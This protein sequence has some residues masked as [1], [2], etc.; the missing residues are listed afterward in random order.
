M[1]GFPYDG[2]D[3]NTST[4]GHKV[5]TFENDIR[6]V[7]LTVVCALKRE[8]TNKRLTILSLAG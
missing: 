5:L 7:S 3:N 6:F 2:S 8:T 4:T 1:Y